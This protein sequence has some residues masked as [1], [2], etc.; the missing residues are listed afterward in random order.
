MADPTG[1][2][3]QKII[4]VLKHGDATI[5]ELQTMRGFK[6][7]NSKTIRNNLGRMVSRGLLRIVTRMCSITGNVVNAYSIC[8]DDGRVL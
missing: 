2:N 4:R 1:I 5:N 7:M 3:R 8:D 6:T